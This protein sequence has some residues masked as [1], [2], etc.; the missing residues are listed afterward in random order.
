[1]VCGQ[2]IEAPIVLAN[3]LSTVP[4]KPSQIHKRPKRARFI[5]PIST[6]AIVSLAMI[7]LL[8]LAGGPISAAVE[9]AFFRAEPL[10]DAVQLQWATTHEYNMWGFQVYCKEELQPNVDYHPVGRPIPAKGSLEQGAE[11]MFAVTA[12]KPG[13]SYCFRIEELTTDGQPG[14]VFEICGYGAQVTP[15]PTVTPTSTATPTPT[16]TPT[17]THTPE[18]STSP[19]NPPATPSPTLP[20]EAQTVEPTP[21]IQVIIPTATEAPAQPTYVIM[22]ATPTAT[23][24]APA[25]TPTPLPTATPTPSGLAFLGGGGAVS[26]ADLLVLLLCAGGLG[27]G[28][29]GL[30]SLLGALF[31]IRSREEDYR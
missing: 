18:P 25:T 12:L 19:I 3:D 17:P 14:E 29:L 7:A 30:M 6:L 13:V 28:A 27:V 2:P 11:Y 10:A 26:P 4:R 15:T 16:L 21:Q 23:R 22:T 20:A 8:L 31:Y 5:R 9:V 24:A 1:M